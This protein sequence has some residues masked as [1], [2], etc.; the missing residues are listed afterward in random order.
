M[1]TEHRITWL[2]VAD[3]SRAKVFESSSA[4]KAVHALDDMTLAEDLPKSRELLTDRPGRTFDS[5]GGGRH[6]KENPSD[7]LRQRKREFAKKVIA[8]L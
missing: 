5:V 6:A 1:P 4:R 8:E 2:L 3:A 7:P